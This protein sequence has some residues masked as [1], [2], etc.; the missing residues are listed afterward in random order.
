VETPTDPVPLAPEITSE[1]LAPVVE[2]PGPTTDPEP[3]VTGYIDWRAIVPPDTF[4]W[5]W[6]QTTCVMDTPD[7]YLFWNGLIAT[8]FAGGNDVKMADWTPVKANFF[9]CHF[10][11]SG[12]GKSRS[13]IPL[14]ELLSE[15][16]P[17]DHADPSNTGVMMTKPSSAESLIDAFSKD[18]LDPVTSERIGWAPVRGLVQYGELSDLLG[19]TAR[20]GNTL[21]PTLMEFYDAHNDVS[22]RSRGSGHIHAEKPFCQTITTTQT[23]SVADL[24]RD[25]DAD[26][27]FL[28]RWVFVTC[29][30]KR[31]V[32]V[33]GTRVTIDH[34]CEPLRMIRAWASRGRSITFDDA[35]LAAFQEWFENAYLPN[36]GDDDDGEV[37]L[38]RGDLLM[39][40]LIVAFC[41]NS[42][43]E[44]ATE[45]IVKD[46]LSLWPYLGGSYGVVRD[47][48]GVVETHE[49]GEAVIKAI[50]EFNAL[51]VQ[52]TIRD[53]YERKL[54][55]RFKDKATVAKT[56]RLM[57]EL[58]E[59]KEVLT[60][61]PVNKSVVTRYEL[62]KDD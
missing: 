14:V 26:S 61:H 9:I 62:T 59:I 4:L 7:E 8:S 12:T 55:G 54:K 48:L 5:D 33:G 27:G 38:Q 51:G 1:H 10:G 13:L 45:Q 43:T 19:K 22:T 41:I 30:P 25:A 2:M 60:K 44:V 37:L 42:M 35:G 23:K 16:L 53:L 20:M 46:A 29:T 28:N 32:A 36:V 31:R 58:E 56:L 52:P 49:I 24:L 50:K 34:L 6:M 18:I 47:R 17:Y 57:C 3:M 21:K 11:G 39:K 40:K 15:A